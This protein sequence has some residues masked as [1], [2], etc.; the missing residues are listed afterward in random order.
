MSNFVNFEQFARSSGKLV[1]RLLDAWEIYDMLVVES[2]SIYK[3]VYAKKCLLSKFETIILLQWQWY[4]PLNLFYLVQKWKR[5][6][7]N[8]GYSAI[9][10]HTILK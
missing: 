8:P 1:I 9:Q 4:H 6:L 5:N 10:F 3:Q 2:L 7:I